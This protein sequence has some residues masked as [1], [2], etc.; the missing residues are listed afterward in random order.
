MDRATTG[1]I[2]YIGIGTYTSNSYAGVVYIDSV[3]DL[4]LSGGWNNEFTSKTGMS[5]VD[6]QNTRRGFYSSVGTVTFEN[7]IIQNGYDFGSGGGVDNFHG[8][9][10]INNSVIRNN[11]SDW[12]GAGIENF[13]TLTINNTSINN[14]NA[15]DQPCCNGTGSGIHNYSGTITVNNSV[16]FDNSLLSAA[17]GTA[18]KNF[19]TLFL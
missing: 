3:K 9:M 2:I 7:F 15:G 1:D 13:G 10:T 17:E 6:G 12:M 5:T 8:T 16:I 18:I 19:G 11:V 4:F 14:N